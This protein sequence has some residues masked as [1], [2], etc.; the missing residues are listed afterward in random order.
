[1]RKLREPHK[2]PVKAGEEF[3]RWV[4][5]MGFNPNVEMLLYVQLGMVR[6][7]GVR[8]LGW[9]AKVHSGVQQVAPQ[10]APPQDKSHLPLWHCVYFRNEFRCTYYN[11]D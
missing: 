3:H 2:F 5:S 1:M 4:T 10:I 7:S 6:T 9:S 11:I 8:F